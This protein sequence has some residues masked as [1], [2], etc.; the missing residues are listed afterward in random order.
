M[1]LF[2]SSFTSADANETLTMN[3]FYTYQHVLIVDD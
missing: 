2:C 1:E 3:M